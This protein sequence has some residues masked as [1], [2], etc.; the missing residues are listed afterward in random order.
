M[1]V[2]DFATRLFQPLKR[3]HGEKKEQ[4][5]KNIKYCKYVFAHFII[6][7][8]R[9]REHRIS[10][11]SP[12]YASNAR[13]VDVRYSFRAVFFFVSR[14]LKAAFKYYYYCS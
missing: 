8:V 14:T 11:N 5:K 2:D 6:A 12:F 1:R 7:N 9:R 4:T 3:A 10:P 13:A